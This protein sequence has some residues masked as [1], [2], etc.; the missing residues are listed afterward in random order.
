[1]RL[2]ETYQPKMFQELMG[3]APQFSCNRRKVAQ[4]CNHR[5][6]HESEPKISKQLGVFIS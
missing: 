4:V 3:R 5:Q 1:M 2:D 6:K